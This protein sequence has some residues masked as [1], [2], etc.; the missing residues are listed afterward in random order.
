[1]GRNDPPVLRFFIHHYRIDIFANEK[2]TTKQWE[3]FNFIVYLSCNE[4]SNNEYL[5]G[6]SGRC[7][8]ASPTLASMG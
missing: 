1:M 4:R 6:T 8:K 5:V 7:R 3:R 2:F